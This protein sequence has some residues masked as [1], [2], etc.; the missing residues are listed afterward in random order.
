LLAALVLSTS[1]C[2]GNETAGDGKEPTP[3]PS[4][5]EPA[6][7]GAAG[8]PSASVSEL[9]DYFDELT[10]LQAEVN[11]LVSEVEADHL[12][13]SDPSLSIQEQRSSTR[14]FINDLAAGIDAIAPEFQ[15]IQPPAEVSEAHDLF[16]GNMVT[17]PALLRDVLSAVD[18][19]PPEEILGGIALGAYDSFSSPCAE[20]QQIADRNGIKIELDW[21]GRFAC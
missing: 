14:D 2:R 15:A 9:Q 19:A 5:G 1:A 12:E 8:S 4:Q 20:L 21:Q 18:Q 6:S 7:T 11:D 3:P 16:V 17:F 10:A 13:L